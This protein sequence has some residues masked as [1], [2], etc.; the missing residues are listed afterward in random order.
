MKHLSSTSILS[1]ILTAVMVIL[2]LPS[3]KSKRIGN[4]ESVYAGPNFNYYQSL[5]PKE[6]QQ[7]N[8]DST[9]LKQQPTPTKE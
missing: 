8:I 9:A 2:G 5:T 7:L 6:Q 3:C 4:V 1:S